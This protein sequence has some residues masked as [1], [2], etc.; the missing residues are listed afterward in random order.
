MKLFMSV[1]ATYNDE[2]EN[3]VREFENFIA[4]SG[5]QKLTVGRGNYTSDQP[6]AAARE[7][8]RAADGVV[9]I[10]FTRQIIEKSIE[11]P[12]S[13]K[14]KNLEN[15]RTTTIWNQLEAAMAFALDLPILMIIEYGLHQEAMIKD[16]YEYRVLQTNIDM[17]FFSDEE[18]KGIF[19]DWQKKI[20]A[21]KNNKS[22]VL[23]SGDLTLD[24]IIRGLRPSE[25]WKLGGAL[26]TVFAIVAG[27]TYWLA[28][29]GII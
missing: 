25:I 11:K 1:G 18:F 29:S 15:M 7:L 6:V 2:Q 8:M 20:N 21:S 28:D 16:R 9:V 3:F 24:S 5:C 22:K 14:E 10:A 23:N 17:G 26:I 12:G 27:V 13:D 4:Q 19:A